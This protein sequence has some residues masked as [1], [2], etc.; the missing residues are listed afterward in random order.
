MIIF[1]YDYDHHIMISPLKK[2]KVG[3]LANLKTS[4]PI[5][6]PKYLSSH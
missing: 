5:G 2:N 4:N 3:L 1:R 6:K